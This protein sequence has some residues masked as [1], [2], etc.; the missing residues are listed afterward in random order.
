MKTTIT[1]LIICRR[2]IKIDIETKSKNMKNKP[3]I[4]YL[5]EKILARG[6]EDA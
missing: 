6:N 1:T 5:Y 4:T 2:T 3:L